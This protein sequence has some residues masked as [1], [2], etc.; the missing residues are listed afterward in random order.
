MLYQRVAAGLLAVVLL[1]SLAGCAGDKT[2]AFAFDI[3]QDPQNL[4]PQLATDS[5]SL[6]VLQNT[7]EGLM[8]YAS[9]GALTEGAAR[10]YTVSPDGQTYVFTL[11]EQSQWIY[12]GEEYAPVTAHDFVFAFQ[13]IFDTN[14]ASPY[15]KEFMCLRNAEEVEAGTKPKEALGVYASKTYELTVELA[16]PFDGFLALTA[17]TPAMPCNP[18]L[19]TQTKGKYGTNIKNMAFNGPF[20]LSAWKEGE[21]LTL[22]KNGAYHRADEVVPSRVVLYPGAQAADSE[23]RFLDGQTD[24]LSVPGDRIEGLVTQGFGYAQ[25]QDITWALLLNTADPAFSN[26]NVRLAFAHAFTNASYVNQ[27][28]IWLK[29]AGGLIP[30]VV[31]SGA[32]PYRR[33]AGLD[34]M[35]SYDPETARAL[36]A[37]GLAELELTKLSGVKVLCPQEEPFGFLMQYVQQTWQDDLSAFVTL[38]RKSGQEIAQAVKDG[39][40]QIA[41]VPLRPDSDNVGEMLS[42]FSSDSPKNVTGYRSEEYDALLAAATRAATQE[43]AVEKLMQAERQLIGQAALIPFAYQT[44]FYAVAPNARDIII[45]PFGGGLYFKYASIQEQ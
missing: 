45:S 35:L 38:E 42:Q 37:Q 34:L 44:S 26:Q 18:A 8:S 28:P 27:F 13:R 36:L 9:D 21:S 14:T 23:A 41:L 22:K 6:L 1:L 33:T 11:D 29:R 10:S 19:F 16:Y 39:G 30:P 4:D 40:Y 20:V 17:T 43:Q 3:A 25:F 12:R 7:L 31:T 32:Q 2:T 24:V 15:K 5:A